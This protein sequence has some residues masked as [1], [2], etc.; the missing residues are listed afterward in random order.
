MY[1][2]LANLCFL[3]TTST[4]C[5][6]AIGIVLKV[7]DSIG[8]IVTPN[9]ISSSLTFCLISLEPSSIIC[10]C[11][12]GYSSWN[13]AIIDGKYAAPITGGSPSFSTFFE[14]VKL[15][16]S[17]YISKFIVTDLGPSIYSSLPLYNHKGFDL[18]H[19]WMV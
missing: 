5:P 14:Y 2:L 18:G 4:T 6:F 11:I 3:F 15:S 17:L 13:L 19:T 7:F 9:S 12:S 8:I 16:S 1:F 10:I